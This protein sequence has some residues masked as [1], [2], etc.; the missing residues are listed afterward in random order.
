MATLKFKV[1]IPDWLYRYR[2]VNLKRYA[3]WL[4]FPNKCIECG[5]QQPLKN[6]DIEWYYGDALEKSY[7]R[8]LIKWDIEGDYNKCICPSCMAKHVS[9]ENAVPKLGRK[10][11]NQ[12]D[13]KE[14]CDACGKHKKS[15]KW[16]AFKIK[17]GKTAAFI[18]GDYCSWNSAHYCVDCIRQGILE[19]D[20]KGNS[21]YG[22]YKNKSVPTN[23]FGLPVVDG[24]V[25]FPDR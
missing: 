22:R 21:I 4:F 12:Y 1:N 8:M 6:P 13:V 15:H 14:I 16:T 18:M 11:Y 3:K 2:Y 10:K 25:K 23:N 5:K 17:N 9:D 24:K 19:G 7:G 20:T